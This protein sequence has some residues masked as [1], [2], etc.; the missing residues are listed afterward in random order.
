M[1][2]RIGVA[3]LDAD[4]RGFYFGVAIGIRPGPPG[5]R[6][7]TPINL[8]NTTTQPTPYGPSR[9]VRVLRVR[10]LRVRHIRGRAHFRH[11][12]SD[13]TSDL[14]GGT[15]ERRIRPLSKVAPYPTRTSPSVRSRRASLSAGRA[16][17]LL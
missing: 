6:H 1:S 5:G 16:V 11:S 15:S 10:A 14:S 12:G 7:F 2:H 8:L 17:I 13:I 4:W 3:H 9:R